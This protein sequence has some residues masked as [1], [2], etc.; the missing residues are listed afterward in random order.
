M[1]PTDY[2][3][4]ESLSAEIADL[5]AERDRLRALN[6]ELLTAL[7]MLIDHGILHEDT[8]CPEDD[9]CTCLVADAVSAAIRKAEQS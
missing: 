3:V 4:I 7:K 8:S 5:T 9:T 6:A 1:I 2:E